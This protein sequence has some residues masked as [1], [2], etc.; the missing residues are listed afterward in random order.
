MCENKCVCAKNSFRYF[1]ARRYLNLRALKMEQ[2]FKMIVGQNCY[3]ICVSKLS[4]ST[5]KEMAN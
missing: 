1:N 3:R 4:T 2:S 5:K